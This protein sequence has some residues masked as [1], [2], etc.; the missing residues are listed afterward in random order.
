MHLLMYVMCPRDIDPWSLSM[1][2]EYY[3]SF[4][5]KQSMFVIPISCMEAVLSFDRSM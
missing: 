4:R 1:Y 2:G 3:P 5:I